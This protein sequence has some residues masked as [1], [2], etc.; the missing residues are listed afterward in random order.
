MDHPRAPTSTHPV[1]HCQVESQACS[2]DGRK[3]CPPDSFFLTPSAQHASVDV[4]SK[5]EGLRHPSTKRLEA[6]PARTRS[7]FPSDLQ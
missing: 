2:V 3:L 1:P 6:V 4:C 7:L 5:R